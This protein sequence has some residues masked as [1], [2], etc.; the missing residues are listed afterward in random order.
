MP[1][2]FCSPLLQLAEH[3]KSVELV[4]LPSGTGQHIASLDAGEIDV[5]IAL[6][7]VRFPSHS[8]TMLTCSSLSSPALQ[9]ER[10]AT[11]LS[12]STSCHRSSG[13]S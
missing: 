8:S 3:D 11:N 4:S 12:V 2:H 13:G 10:L 1:E 7:E 6:T 9:R 5:S